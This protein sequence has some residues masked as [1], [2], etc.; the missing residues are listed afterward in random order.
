M[1]KPT[2]TIRRKKIIVPKQCYFCSER[3][4]PAFLDVAVLMRYITDRGKIIGRARNG[5]CAK[6]QRHLTTEIKYARHLALMPF[7]VRD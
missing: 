5:L 7:V 6:H 2:K 1:A 4:Q 3:K